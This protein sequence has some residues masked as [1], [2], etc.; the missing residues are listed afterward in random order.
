MSQT[1]EKLKEIPSPAVLQLVE[2]SYIAENEED[3]PRLLHVTFTDGTRKRLKATHVN[4]SAN[5]LK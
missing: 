4:E 1:N 3:Q 2:V 5:G